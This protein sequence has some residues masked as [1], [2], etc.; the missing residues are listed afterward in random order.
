MNISA[1]DGLG[2]PGALLLLMVPVAGN[3]MFFNSSS[4]GK[5]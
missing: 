4:K 2:K 5:E 3:D 1:F